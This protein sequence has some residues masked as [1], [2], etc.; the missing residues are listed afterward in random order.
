M[1]YGGGGGW[2]K[3]SD[4]IENTVDRRRKIE[5]KKK[6]TGWN[7]Q[8]QTPNKQNLDQNIDDWIYL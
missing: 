2:V 6:K 4:T 5:K 7:P 3:M 8:N 1:F